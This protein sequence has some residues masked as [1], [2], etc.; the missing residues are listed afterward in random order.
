[1]KS[2]D[3]QEAIKTKQNDTK[4]IV[5]DDSIGEFLKTAFISLKNFDSV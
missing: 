1:V 4:I 2:S 3:S 5:M